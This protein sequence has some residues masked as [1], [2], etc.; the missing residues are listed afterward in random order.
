MF[1]N[2]MPDL[3]VEIN[4]HKVTEAKKSNNFIWGYEIIMKELQALLW[5]K[6]EKVE[7]STVQSLAVSSDPVDLY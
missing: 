1:D 5:I 3:S 7:V 4:S 6:R 2:V